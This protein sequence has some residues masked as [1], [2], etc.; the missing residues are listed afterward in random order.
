MKKL[1]R[2][3]IQTLERY[4]TEYHDNKKKLKFREWEL[5]NPGGQEELVG[6]RSSGISDS[7]GRKA[8]I[9]LSDALYQNLQRI[10]K[11]VEV[12]Y[13]NLDEEMQTIVDM[14]YWS[15]E[16]VYEWEDIADELRISRNKVLRYRNILIDKTA[17]K[18]GWV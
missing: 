4:W 14:R 6:G 11:A 12:L 10:I 7:T 16:V 5:L 9:L 13:N 1:T 17:E 15:G 3:D 8:G 2:Y 18:V